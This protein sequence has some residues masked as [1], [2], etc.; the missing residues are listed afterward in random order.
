MSDRRVRRVIA[1]GSVGNLPLEILRVI[2]QEVHRAGRR[3][4]RALRRYIMKIQVVNA[5][6]TT[7]EWAP[8]FGIPIPMSIYRYDEF[9][10]QLRRHWQSLAGWTP[11]QIRHFNRSYYLTYDEAPW[12]PT[13]AWQ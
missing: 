4:R 2:W 13:S 1:T 3:A 9:P 7:L 8:G 6:N 10:E 5:F 12:P 11:R